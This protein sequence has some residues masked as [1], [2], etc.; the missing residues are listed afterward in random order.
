[1]NPDP[2]ALNGGNYSSQPWIEIRYAEVLLNRAEAAWELV[3]LGEVADAKGESYLSIATEA[4]NSI[5]KELEQRN[6]PRLFWPMK[7]S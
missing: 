3:S 2:K 5:R 7:K 4:I 1:M 6:Y